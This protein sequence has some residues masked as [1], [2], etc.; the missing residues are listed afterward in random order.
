MRSFW[1]NLLPG[2]LK[3]IHSI[4]NL[5]FPPISPEEMRESDDKKNQATFAI[6]VVG[7]PLFQ[8]LSNE[9]NGWSLSRCISVRRERCRS[10]DMRI[11]ARFTNYS[12]F[13][14]IHTSLSSLQLFLEWLEPCPS[15]QVDHFILFVYVSCWVKFL[16]MLHM[17][18]LSFI[19]LCY[20]FL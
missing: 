14:A 20:S 12:P 18:T 10:I 17:L 3:L 7:G 8:D 1:L 15:G 4:L 9:R 11:C 19:S 13:E 6:R 2:S 5:Y 16:F